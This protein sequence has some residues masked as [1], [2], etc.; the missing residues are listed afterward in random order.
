MRVADLS[1]PVTYNIST[2]IRTASSSTI[3]FDPE[4]NYSDITSH[5]REVL[6]CLYWNETTLAW[7]DEGCNISQT[8]DDM[9][10]CACNHLTTFGTAFGTATS[11]F[12]TTQKE[13]LLDYPSLSLRHPPTIVIFTWLVLIFLPMLV[14]CWKDRETDWLSQRE[15]L[16]RDRYPRGT[17]DMMFMVCPPFSICDGAIIVAPVRVNVSKTLRSIQNCGSS[18]P[19]CCWRSLFRALPASRQLA[20]S[21]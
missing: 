6:A 5:T 15:D 19:S 21:N 16:F 12:G 1:S 14:C 20:S 3:S 7:S 2:P 4:L 13:L 17:V 11:K 10:V 8:F 18:R 9:I